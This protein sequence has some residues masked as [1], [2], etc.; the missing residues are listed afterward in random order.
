MENLSYLSESISK[1]MM[2]LEINAGNAGKIIDYF[3]NAVIKTPSSMRSL[4][5]SLKQALAG[6]SNFADLTSKSGMELENYKLQLIQ[7]ATSLSGG[8]S[9]LGRKG[10]QL[11][12]KT[13]LFDG[14]ILRVYNTKL[15]QQCA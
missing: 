4:Q 9:L 14:E 10:K 5:E 13:P 15:R 8:M 12:L 7:T 11:C 1:A 6:F 3:H 2:T